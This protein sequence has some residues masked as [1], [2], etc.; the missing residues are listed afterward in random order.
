[1]AVKVLSVVQRNVK[2][3]TLILAFAVYIVPVLAWDVEHDVIAQLTGEFLPAEIKAT[4]D[5]DDFARLTAYCHY[6]DMMEW[7]G[8]GKPRRWAT[9]DE[10]GAIVEIVFLREFQG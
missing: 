1:M 3:A 8:N 2:R 4:F 6:P 9:L 5:A 7:D 10:T